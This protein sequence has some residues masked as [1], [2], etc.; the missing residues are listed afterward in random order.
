MPGSWQ[1]LSATCAVPECGRP[2]FRS[3]PTGWVYPGW[4]NVHRPTVCR[5]HQRQYANGE[6]A[7]RDIARY[8]KSG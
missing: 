8:G 2:G 7:P 4:Y 6:P 3:V 5:S 1:T